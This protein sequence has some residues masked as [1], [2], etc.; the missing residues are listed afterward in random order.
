MAVHNIRNDFINPRGKSTH[1]GWAITQASAGTPSISE[2]TDDDLGECLEISFTPT[3]A[4]DFVDIQLTNAGSW[5]LVYPYGVT[6]LR[7]PMKVISAGA[8]P[9]WNGYF[10]YAFTPP[11]QLSVSERLKND[12]I[13]LGQVYEPEVFEM[14]PATTV[15]FFSKPEVKIVALDS[16]PITF[17]IKAQVVLYPSSGAHH[18]GDIPAYCDGTEDNCVW[19]GAADASASH[20]TVDVPK[21]KWVGFNEL[22]YSEIFDA[23][24][25]IEDQPMSPAENIGINKQMGANVIR[26]S[27]FLPRVN[28]NDPIT[29]PYRR[30]WFD[31]MRDAGMKLIV[32]CGSPELWMSSQGFVD[33]DPS[34]YAEIGRAAAYLAENWGDIIVAYEMTNEPNIGLSW[35]GFTVDATPNPNKYVDIVKVVYD[36]IKAVDSDATIVAGGLARNNNDITGTN[37]QTSIYNFLNKMYLRCTSLGISPPWDGISLHPYPFNAS[38]GPGHAGGTGVF[39]KG[40]GLWGNMEQCRNALAAHGAQGTPLWITEVG[41]ITALGST[42][43]ADPRQL[44]LIQATMVALIR[45]ALLRQNDVEAVCIHG[46]WSTDSDAFGARGW[47]SHAIKPMGEVIAA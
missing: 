41:Y 14:A 7:T 1:S 33:L 23:F 24:T 43:I 15:N 18:W 44:D 9:V 4:F 11:T 27:C 20:G 46:L 19:E 34:Y 45:G 39:A 42:I 21:D 26:T 47:P 38:T 16:T 29:Y 13:P 17:R 3:A 31:A 36:A 10:V 40:A 22:T 28:Q 8:N 37:K 30:E 32:T 12:Y 25:N 6:Y 2:V 5:F 35:S